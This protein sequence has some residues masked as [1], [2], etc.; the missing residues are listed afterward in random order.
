MSTGNTA[1]TNDGWKI[2]GALW[3]RIEILL[4]P[5]LPHPAVID[6]PWNREKRWMWFATGC[7]SGPDEEKGTDA[8][9]AL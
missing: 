4:P 6:M 1:V 2:P 5:P 7:M 3:E 8:P 9:V